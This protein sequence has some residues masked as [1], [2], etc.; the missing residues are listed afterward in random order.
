M[1][2]LCLLLPVILLA[3]CGESNQQASKDVPEI[4]AQGNEPFWTVI[5]E[6]GHLKYQT[7]EELIGESV[8]VKAKKKS[9]AWHYKAE[10]EAGELHLRV[11]EKECQDD[12]SG[13]HFQY[14]AEIEIQGETHNG[15][16]NPI[17]VEPVKE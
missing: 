16:A 8:S 17:D 3:A 6:K 10:V 7:P 2:K 4:R 11:K 15:C 13:W 1:K 14:T 12:M 9:D 5:V